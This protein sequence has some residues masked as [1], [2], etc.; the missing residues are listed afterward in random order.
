MSTCT[1]KTTGLQEKEANAIDRTSSRNS[2]FMDNRNILLRP[3]VKGCST[4]MNQALFEPLCR[5]E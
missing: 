2:R 1:H 4:D 5:A 3:Q